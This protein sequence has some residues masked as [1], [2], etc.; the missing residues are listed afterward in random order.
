M[1]Y[2]KAKYPNQS[3]SYTFRTEDEVKAGD[4]VVNA[5]GVKLIV[6][7]E[8]V[9]MDWVETYGADKVAEVK[10]L[11]SGII[12]KEWSLFTD[13]DHPEFKAPEILHYH[14][15]GKAYG[16]PKFNDGDPVNTSRIVDIKEFGDH[17]EATTRSGS[18]YI[19]SKED[20]DPECEKQFPNYYERFCMKKAVEDD[21]A[22]PM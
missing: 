22:E 7:G 9:D 21:E 11:P 12:L 10:L 5:K 16:H 17:K 1:T 8:F 15:Q 14:L 4:T 18:V 2:I 19:L 20:V 13:V 3:K 6:T